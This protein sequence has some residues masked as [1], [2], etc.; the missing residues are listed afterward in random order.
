M[1]F[2]GGKKNPFFFSICGPNYL[3]CCNSEACKLVN[4]LYEKCTLKQTAS[5]ALSLSKCQ[6]IFEL[7]WQGSKAQMVI[8]K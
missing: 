8:F 7:I 4:D 6:E 2:C 3:P 5:F 1:K